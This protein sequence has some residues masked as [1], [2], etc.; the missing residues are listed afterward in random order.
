MKR[1]LH[2]TDNDSNKA[3]KKIEESLLLSRLPN[4]LLEE[5]CLR[6]DLRDWPAIARTCKRLREVIK[7]AFDHSAA[8]CGQTSNFGP[9][10]TPQD[11]CL[12]FENGGGSKVT[13]TYDQAISEADA[14]WHCLLDRHPHAAIRQTPVAILP[15]RVKL[16]SDKATA[17]DDGQGKKKSELSNIF[18]AVVGFTSLD[19]ID[20]FAG[21]CQ[22]TRWHNSLPVAVGLSVAGGPKLS[23]L[24]S[25]REGS[26]TNTI[27]EVEGDFDD[28]QMFVVIDERSIRYLTSG[29]ELVC[30]HLWPLSKA[31]R[32]PLVG[33]NCRGETKVTFGVSSSQ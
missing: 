8:R 29:R 16:H 33:V 28:H 18:K 32:V 9:L 19:A 11:A 10:E 22:R 17:T 4:N 25:S 27:K 3:Q 30:F 15:V 5:I 6:T 1:R 26:R 14:A 13:S 23:L 12:R 2:S 7:Q 31:Q 20:K 24:E 21:T